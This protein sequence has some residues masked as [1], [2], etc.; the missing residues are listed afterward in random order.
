MD[1]SILLRNFIKCFLF[2]FL[3]FLLIEKTAAT[4]FHWPHCNR[5]L[6]QCS[7]LVQILLSS[8]ICRWSFYVVTIETKRFKIFWKSNEYWYQIKNLSHL[9]LIT[10]KNIIKEPRVDCKYLN[11]LKI[12]NNNEKRNWNF[13]PLN[14]V[15]PSS[16]WIFDTLCRSFDCTIQ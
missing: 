9:P 10:F 13:R 16:L 8:L 2:F 6:C 14:V 1:N 5:V 3:F 11:K 4:F 7:L 15:T 12:F